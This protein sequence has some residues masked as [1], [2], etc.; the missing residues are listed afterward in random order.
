MFDFAIFVIALIS[1][2]FSF[3]FECPFIGSLNCLPKH[4]YKVWITIAEYLKGETSN[5]LLFI[6]QFIFLHIL[7]KV[8]TINCIARIHKIISRVVKMYTILYISMNMLVLYRPH[9]MLSFWMTK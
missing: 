1:Y 8:L 6:L 9:L 3:V 2:N 7:R 5:D 4:L